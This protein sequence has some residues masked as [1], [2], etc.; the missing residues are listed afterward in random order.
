MSSILL[1]DGLEIQEL[2]ILVRLLDKGVVPL[3]NHAFTGEMVKPMTTEDENFQNL[4]QKCV[5]VKDVFK[6][7]EIPSELVTGYSAS[8]ALCRMCELQKMNADWDNL[9][10]F[11]RYAVLKEL[12]DTVK[13]DIALLSNDTLFSLVSCYLNMNDK[14]NVSGDSMSCVCGDI[15][16]RMVDGK[17][18]IQELCRINSI[19][20]GSPKG[21][22][23]LLK[24]IWAHIANRYG[25]ITEDDMPVVLA[26]LPHSHRFL[27][28]A[29]SRQMHRYWWKMTA[30]QVNY[31]FI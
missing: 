6:L 23:D 30:N 7:L 8:A 22:K 16:K 12:N 1:Q 4:L 18:S 9:H 5:S 28:K 14:E 29:L 3:T 10:S 19:L 31:F 20:Q 21:D 17:I 11:I 26:S 2:P 13:R 15:E 25:D 27:L 24:A